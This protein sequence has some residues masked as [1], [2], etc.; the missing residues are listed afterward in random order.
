[1]H[2]ILV[3]RSGKML[4]YSG[5]IL[6]GLTLMSAAGYFVS[7]E[8]ITTWRDNSMYE[9]TLELVKNNE[10]VPGVFIRRHFVQ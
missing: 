8:M 5:V 1:M 2:P 7:Q 3:V 6:A 10:K 9:E 4:G